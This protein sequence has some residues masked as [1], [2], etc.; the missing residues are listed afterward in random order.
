[1]DSSS[2]TDIPGFSSTLHVYWFL[3]VMEIRPI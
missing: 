2:L 1:M 3:L